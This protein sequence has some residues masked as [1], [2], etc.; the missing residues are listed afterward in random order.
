M[1]LK[2]EHQ[3]IRPG[4][5]KVLGF[6]MVSTEGDKKT[7]KSLMWYLYDVEPKLWC[8]GEIA[9]EWGFAHPTQ[10]FSAPLHSSD[11][12]P[13]FPTYQPLL[14]VFIFSGF[15]ISPR[16]VFLS[17]HLISSEMRRDER[18]THLRAL[19]TQTSGR[20]LGP[21]SAFQAISNGCLGSL[22]SCMLMLAEADTYPD[23][24]DNWS[25]DHT[26]SI[27]LPQHLNQTLTVQSVLN[28]YL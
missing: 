10:M 20:A 11:H 12:H 15:I 13:S 23:R 5:G 3:F 1:N 6:L 9:T 26:G 2:Q 16:W 18:S 24:E 17:S 4:A 22:A 7:K 21:S 25:C 27:K 8:S 28:C 14:C 19:F